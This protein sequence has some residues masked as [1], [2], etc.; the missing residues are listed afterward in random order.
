MIR[1]SMC[2]MSQHFFSHTRDQEKVKKTLLLGY[3]LTK[4]VSSVDS[5]TCNLSADST[6]SEDSEIATRTVA[7][8]TLTA[9][10]T[11]HLA[12][13]HPHSASILFMYD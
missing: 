6:V 3:R 9:R 5:F 2:Y 8:L 1:G 11:N 13:S 12:R 4:V 10:R 7:T